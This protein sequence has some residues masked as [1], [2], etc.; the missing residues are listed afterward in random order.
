MLPLSLPSL[1][2]FIPPSDFC[3]SPSVFLPPFLISQLPPSLPVSSGLGVKAE[4]VSTHHLCPEI[5]LCLAC[6]QGWRRCV[7]QEHSLLGK[8]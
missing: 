8:T 2:C 3:C 5:H 6:G 7:A 4:T 1:P